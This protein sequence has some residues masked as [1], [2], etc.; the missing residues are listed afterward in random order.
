MRA[1]RRDRPDLRAKNL[2]CQKPRPVSL[3]KVRQ[4]DRDSLTLEKAQ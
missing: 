2:N 1:N 3:S 4:L